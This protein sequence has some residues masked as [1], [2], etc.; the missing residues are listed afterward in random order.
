[1]VA[2]DGFAPRAVAGA[3]GGVSEKLLA[4]SKDAMGVAGSDLEGIN[5][6]SATKHLIA[7]SVHN[8]YFV[9]EQ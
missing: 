1:M 4:C 8:P 6:F 5:L 9:G 7:F 2:H 3:G